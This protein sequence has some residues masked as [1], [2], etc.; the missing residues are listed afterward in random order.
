MKAGIII[1]LDENEKIIR[2]SED[3]FGNMVVE[4][5]REIK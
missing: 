4:K 3:E 2:V 1:N 5:I